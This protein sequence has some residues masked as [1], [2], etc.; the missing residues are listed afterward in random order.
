MFV[1]YVCIQTTKRLN[2]SVPNLLSHDPSKGGSEFKKMLLEKI[3]IFYIFELLLFQNAQKA[4]RKIS[5]PETR[6]PKKRVVTDKYKFKDQNT[7]KL[8]LKKPN[9]SSHG[10]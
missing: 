9:N 1:W 7:I 10:L 4:C 2:Q 5:Y 6:R 8:K 3:R